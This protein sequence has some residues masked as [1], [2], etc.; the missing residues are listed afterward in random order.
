M[1]NENENIHT[2]LQTGNNLLEDLDALIFT[3]NQLKIKNIAPLSSDI[4][5]RQTSILD[6]MSNIKLRII[7]ICTR[8][9]RLKN[10][11]KLSEDSISMV[12]RFLYDCIR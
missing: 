2:L 7:T 3:Y 1:N 4:I 10:K 11:E 6:N 12:N 9:L 8:I 5:E